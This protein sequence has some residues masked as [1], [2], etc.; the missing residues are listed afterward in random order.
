MSSPIL[1]LKNLSKQYRSQ[2]MFR[3][4]TALRNLTLNV[5]AGECLGFLGPN[6]SGKTT[7]ITCTLGLVR[8]TSG[9]I[10]FQ[11]SEL[12]SPRQR[13]Q[14]GY[15]SERPYFYDHL[16]V[17]ETLE[18]FAALYGLNSEVRKNSV[19]E[20]IELLGLKDRIRH[21]V[22]ELSKGL[23]QRLA[24]AQ[25]ILHKPKLLFLDEP[26]SGLDPVARAEMRQLFKN[27]KSS[28]TTIF[29][30]SHILSDIEDL[31]DRIAIIK[32]GDLKT[33]FRLSEAEE[34]FGT[35]FSISALIKEENANAW[36]AIRDGAKNVS[37][38]QSANGTLA[39]ALYPSYA[40]AELALH[41]LL[42]AQV[43]IKDFSA[44]RPTLEK[45]FLKIA[46]EDD[47]LLNAGELS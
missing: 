28:G 7:T 5:Y 25:S 17:R 18:Y 30:S 16:T 6:G 15:L 32:A 26:Y 41:K 4:Y 13:T 37:D 9:H 12:R 27:L 19:N 2:W 47:T 44:Q 34:L 24:I 42:H 11:G 29:L 10:F 33:E 1:E 8:K 21:Y 31:C 40:A 46:T 38:V 45:I 35:M 22:G 39:T 3:P 14:M 23:Q 43:T 20:T 36:A